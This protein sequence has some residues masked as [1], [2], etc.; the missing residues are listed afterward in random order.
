VPQALDEALTRLALLGRRAELLYTVP[1]HHNP[2]GVTLSAV[3]PAV[4][5]LARRH[6]VPV[7][8]DDPYGLL[9]FDADPLP[10]LQSLDPAGVVHSARSR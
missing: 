7:V 4:V 1:N 2:S 6:G 10:S 3:R 5:E 8:E 9:G